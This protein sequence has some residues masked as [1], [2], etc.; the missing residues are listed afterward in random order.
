M[1]RVYMMNDDGYYIVGLYEQISGSSGQVNITNIS[2]PHTYAM[3]QMDLYEITDISLD[4]FFGNESREWYDRR[5]E[6]VALDIAR[7]AGVANM[8]RSSH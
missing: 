8:V 1:S 6:A 2:S 3:P 7:Y 4:A 5:K